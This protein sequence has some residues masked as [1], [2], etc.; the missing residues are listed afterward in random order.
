[1]VD[2]YLAS[3]FINT[4]ASEGHGSVLLKHDPQDFYRDFGC[5]SRTHLFSQFRA[6]S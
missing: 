4:F 2:L 6:C 3:L 5:R 1:M